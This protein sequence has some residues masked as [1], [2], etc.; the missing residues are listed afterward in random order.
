MIKDREPFAAVLVA[1][2]W[3]GKRSIIQFLQIERLQMRHRSS[4]GAVERWSGGAVE[5]W[6]GGAVERWSG[7]AVEHRNA[8]RPPR[9]P[10]LLFLF[11]RFTISTLSV[12]TLSASTLHCSN[13]SSPRSLMFPT[14]RRLQFVTVEEGLV[15]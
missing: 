3:F 11:P 1:M 5:R 7:G 10:F 2:Q 14:H 8:F 13:D 4:G 9:F 15:P 12:S 6:S